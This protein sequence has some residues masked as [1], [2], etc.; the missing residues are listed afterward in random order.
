MANQGDIDYDNII[1]TLM[2]TFGNVLSRD[3][4]FAIVESCEGD[5]KYRYTCNYLC[6]TSG[7]LIFLPGI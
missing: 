3:C 1:E 7:L 5:R 2:N 6:D 4:I